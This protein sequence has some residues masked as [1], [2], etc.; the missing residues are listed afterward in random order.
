MADKQSLLFNNLDIKM[1]LSWGIFSL[2]FNK[3]P[4]ICSSMCAYGISLT[5][6]DETSAP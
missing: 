6:R 3:S 4:F 1:K 5:Y 2:N